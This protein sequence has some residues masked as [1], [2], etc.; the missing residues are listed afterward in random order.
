MPR[1]DDLEAERLRMLEMLAECN[2][3]K[4]AIRQTNEENP[5]SDADSAAAIEAR[6]ERNTRH[7]RMCG[8]AAQC[9]MRLTE[10]RAEIAKEK[11]RLH[12]AASAAR[13]AD[14]ERIA[15]ELAA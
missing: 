8:K 12:L 5:P 7:R 2:A 14:R 4:A 6:S 3:I 13:R 9:E 15:R 10:L 1:I 11:A